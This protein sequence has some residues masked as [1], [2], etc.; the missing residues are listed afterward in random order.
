MSHSRPERVAD[1]VREEI[2]VLLSRHVQDPGI[3]FVTVTR[4][5]VTA[6][7]QHARIFYTVIGDDKARKETAKALV[8]VNPFLRRQIAQRINLRRAPELEFF[9]DDTIADAHRME[10]LLQDVREERRLY[11]LANPPGAEPPA[12]PEPGTPAEIEPDAQGDGDPGTGDAPA[13]PDA[14]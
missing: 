5:K 9:Y 1:Q 4:V 3:G 13:E 11:E 14:T 8:R 10:E 6:D 2:T 12:E 7:L